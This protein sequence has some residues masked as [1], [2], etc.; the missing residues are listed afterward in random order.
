MRLAVQGDVIGIDLG[1]P[2]GWFKPWSQQKLGWNLP[3]VT[4][5]I[6]YVSYSEICLVLTVRLAV[7]E[8]CSLW[9]LA[10]A[11]I[12]LSPDWEA[13]Q[14]EPSLGFVE[15]DFLTSHWILTIICSGVFSKLFLSKSKC[16]IWWI[17][18]ITHLSD[19]VRWLF[20]FKMMMF[21]CFELLAYHVANMDTKE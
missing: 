19:L 9:F 8:N 12:L 10:K 21:S 1:A 7:I 18:T 4:C 5:I 2:T 11:T 14:F 15:G 3:N 16:T 13:T 6:M 17:L 20:P